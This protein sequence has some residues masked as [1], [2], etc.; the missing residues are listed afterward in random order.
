MVWMIR[1]RVDGTEVLLP[2]L[3]ILSRARSECSLASVP[4][5]STSHDGDDLAF[6]EE[7]TTTCTEDYKAKSRVIASTT[8]TGHLDGCTSADVGWQFPVCVTTTVLLCF[9][10]TLAQNERRDAPGYELASGDS[11]RAL[12]CVSENESVAC[13]VGS[14]PA[15]QV[16]RCSTRTNPVSIGVS[17]DCENIT[18][19]A[20]CGRL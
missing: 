12:T 4:P 19:G 18:C 3:T 9:A 14:L 17:E 2:R 7:G 20:L 16:T 5:A 8:R 6:Q 13:L 15:R 11:L 1:P 10:S